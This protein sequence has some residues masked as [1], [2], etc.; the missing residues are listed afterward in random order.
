[1]TVGREGGEPDDSWTTSSILANGCRW[2][3]TKGGEDEAGVGG[4]SANTA[5]SSG[6]VLTE[7]QDLG[8]EQHLVDGLMGFR[9][10]TTSS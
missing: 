6:T 7:R 9:V 8:K 1:V 2:R 4:E 10:S 5:K 3:P